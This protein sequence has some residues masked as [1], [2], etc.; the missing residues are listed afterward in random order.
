MPKV[1]GVKP[2]GSCENSQVE[3][4]PRLVLNVAEILPST[5][6]P[7]TIPEIVD[8][9]VMS[10]SEARRHAAK[11]TISTTPTPKNNKRLV[12]KLMSRGIFPSFFIFVFF[13]IMPDVLFRKVNVLIKCDISHV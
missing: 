11:D 12:K 4:P 3:V 7:F 10:M 9:E 1:P 6:L 13:F 8:R 5:V 2:A